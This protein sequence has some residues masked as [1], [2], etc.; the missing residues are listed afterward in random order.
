MFLCAENESQTGFADEVGCVVPD[1]VS[2]LI[3]YTYVGLMKQL[4]STSGSTWNS[5]SRKLSPF[6]TRKLVKAMAFMTILF[7]CDSK[8]QGGTDG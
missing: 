7:I 8:S 1:A 4:S 6:V 2:S 3:A 5:K